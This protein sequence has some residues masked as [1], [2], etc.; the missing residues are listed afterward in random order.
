MNQSSDN[1][2]SQM[3]PVSSAASK[4]EMETRSV[5]DEMT[6]L[7]KILEDEAQKNP[8]PLTAEQIQQHIFQ[9]SS[10]TPVEE[11]I[12]SYPALSIKVAAALFQVIDLFHKGKLKGRNGA[13]CVN[14]LM[15]QIN[16]IPTTLFAY[17]TDLIVNSKFFDADSQH[18]GTVF[19]FLPKFIDILSRSNEIIVGSEIKSTSDYKNELVKRLC[20]FL[21]PNNMLIPLVTS[22]RDTKFDDTELKMII[23][24]IIRQFHKVDLQELPTLIYQLLLFGAKGHHSR[25]LS[26]IFKFFN[27]RET[28]TEHTDDSDIL[29]IQ[30]E[31]SESNANSSE[32]FWRI[33]G[34]VI[35]HIDFAIKRDPTMGSECIKLFKNE[36]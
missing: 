33:E 7:V 31:G 4:H 21:W 32:Q 27:K 23:K 20:S 16:L 34:T 25:I 19:L 9:I 8:L 22:L 5:V 28:F 18:D 12:D 3:T 14:V 36:K 11:T 6:K 13:D 2:P 29:Q 1:V 10:N 24:K 35:F 26:G 15:S 17:F 30:N